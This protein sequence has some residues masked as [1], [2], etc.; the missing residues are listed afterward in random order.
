ML[1]IS[2]ARYTQ[3]ISHNLINGLR[4]LRKH[5]STANTLG[6]K[7]QKGCESNDDHWRYTI[8]LYLTF[9]M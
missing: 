1:L 6:T 7:C 3:E 4:M 2:P 8:K 9:Q 5:V